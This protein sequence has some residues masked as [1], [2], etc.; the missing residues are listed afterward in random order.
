M[1]EI[2][3]YSLEFLVPLLG[4]GCRYALTHQA[5]TIAQHIT[6]QRVKHHVGDAVQQ[7]P[8]QQRKQIPHGKY[9][10]IKDSFHHFTLILGLQN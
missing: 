1:I 6:H 9:K 2:T 4:K 7:P 10:I 3:L 8:R 5:A